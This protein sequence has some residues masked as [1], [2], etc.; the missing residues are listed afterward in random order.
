MEPE[1]VG[2]PRVI[3]VTFSPF[4][5]FKLPGSDSRNRRQVIKD[6]ERGEGRFCFI[7]L[8]DLA[9]E[10][11][12]RGTTE[13]HDVGG[14]EPF[15]GDRLGKTR[16]KSI[17]QLAEEF[18]QSLKKIRDKSRQG[19]FEDIASDLFAESAFARF[20]LM[21][22]SALEDARKLFLTSSTG[23]KIALLI[24]TG[25]LA[26][27]EPYSLVLVDEP[28]THLHPPL[29]AALMHALRKILREH[30][31]FAIVATHSPVVVQESLARHVRIVRRE[32]DTNT[33]APLTGETFGESIGL[34]SAE[35]FGLQTDATD[36]H[37]ILDQLTKGNLS[38]ETIEGLFLNGA[39]SH[40]ARA[41]VMARLS[42]LKQR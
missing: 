5:S 13:T 15:L 30:E 42:T 18:I 23:H 40:Q 39:M 1:G 14:D 12:S 11:T 21:P 6:L 4:D 22:D 31:A 9:A 2:F 34:I 16:L 8:R 3:T 26:N 41:Y 24:V 25:L 20:Q 7:G 33:I 38:L 29:L 17:E 27:L 19:L 28:E 37:N 10:W 32:G 35:V 36:F